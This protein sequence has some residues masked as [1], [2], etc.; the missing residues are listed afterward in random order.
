M[1][2]SSGYTE[3]SSWHEPAMFCIA[4]YIF[5]VVEK[6]YP[7]FNILVYSESHPKNNSSKNRQTRDSEEI[8][9]WL[10]NGWLEGKSTRQ[11]TDQYAWDSHFV[12]CAGWQGPELL[13]TEKG[14]TLYLCKNC[15]TCAKMV[16]SNIQRHAFTPMYSC[17]EQADV[18]QLL[19]RPAPTLSF[20]GSWNIPGKHKTS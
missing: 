4:V 18:P 17:K 3:M 13:A 19:P 8:W 16:A 2:S 12:R 14:K 6:L 5:N 9:R 11:D 10:V 15:F 20:L 7:E 1:F